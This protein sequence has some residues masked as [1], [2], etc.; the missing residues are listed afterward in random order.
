MRTFINSR[1][2]TAVE[3]YQ[4]LEVSYRVALSAWDDYDKDL[5]RIMHSQLAGFK[6]HVHRL[7][8]SEGITWEE[9]FMV[10]TGHNCPLKS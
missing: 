9:Y 3:V 7:R 8:E 6:M 1:I 10:V 5:D 2:K 4:E